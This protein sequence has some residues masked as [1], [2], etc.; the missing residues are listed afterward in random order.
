MDERP[1]KESGKLRSNFACGYDRAEAPPKPKKRRTNPPTKD[2]VEHCTTIRSLP[3]ELLEEILSRVSVSDVIAFG[4]TCRTYHQL[5][6][7]SS[8]WRRLCHRQASGTQQPSAATPNDWRR[9]AILKYSQGLQMQR[10][11]SGWSRTPQWCRSGGPSVSLAVVPPLALGYRRSLPTRDHLLLFDYQGTVFLLRNA[12]T[13]SFRGHMTWRRAA[14]HAVLCQNAKDFAVDPRS[15]NSF[16]QYIY[17]LVSH[18]NSGAEA[19]PPSWPGP[20][21]SAPPLTPPRC[22]CVEVYQQETSQRVFRMTFHPSLTFIQLRLTGSEVNRVLLLVTDTGKVYSLS[23]NETQLNTPRSYTVQ[24]ALKKISISLPHLPIAQ[25]HSSYSSVLYLTG[26]GSV[27]LEVH[28]VGVYRQ[29][30]GTQ[31]GYDPHNI[32][33]PLPLSL[34]YK[35]VKCSLGLS[36]LCLLDDCGRVFMQGSNRYGQLGTGDKI[37]RGEPTE[38]VLS[39]TPVEVWCGL[40]HS[41]ALLQGESGVKEVQ[42]CGCGGGRRLPGCSKGSAVFIKLNIKVP[43]TARSLC[44]SKDCLFLLCCHDIAE[45]PLFRCPPPV[46][47]EEES[48]VAR[49]ER[50]RLIW[51]LSQLRECESLRRKVD[52]LR[53]AVQRHMTINPAHREFLVQALI[54]IRPVSDGPSG[55]S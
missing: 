41:L 39:M 11:G 45:P 29:F 31:Q 23:V 22:D 16:R 21:G 18:T 4:A 3:P 52:I 28:S 1:N 17:V 9:T 34:P 48:E 15:D 13:S 26:E 2:A 35:V 37:D 50:E 10:L 19:V 32:H 27:Y 40:N 12:A 33:T 8:L 42:G 46:K 47:E 30:I 49:D 6:L 36:H 5:S 43:R 55:Q 51:Q 38:V 53:W 54:A 44:A 14:R 24:L 7:S 20:P 25:V